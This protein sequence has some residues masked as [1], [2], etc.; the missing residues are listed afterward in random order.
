MFIYDDRE[1][2][3]LFKKELS[4]IE[5]EDMAKF[6][7]NAI[8]TDFVHS[9][10]DGI[11]NKFDI[12]YFNSSFRKYN[13]RLDKYF[14]DIQ[15]TLENGLLVLIDVAGSDRDDINFLHD[16]LKKML[17]CTELSKIKII[18]SSCERNK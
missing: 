6:R 13:F 4:F 7:D 11:G 18:D 9:F 17:S 10:V 16:Q 2:N 8:S 14:F 12:K 5:N 3:S 1:L 15:N